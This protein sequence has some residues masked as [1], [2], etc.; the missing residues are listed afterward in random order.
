M[1][2]QREYPGSRV[3]SHLILLVSRRRW[4]FELSQLFRW[5]RNRGRGVQMS[6][7]LPT[8]VERWFKTLEGE[9]EVARI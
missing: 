8:G 7:K 1:I 3:T 6:S 5:G 9:R 4:P 2:W